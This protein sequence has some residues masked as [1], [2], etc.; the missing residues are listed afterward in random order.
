MLATL[1][2]CVCASLL[3]NSSV[4]IVAKMRIIF[5]LCSQVRY[6]TCMWTEVNI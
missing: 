5:V 3:E 1:A 4:P 6:L 2:S